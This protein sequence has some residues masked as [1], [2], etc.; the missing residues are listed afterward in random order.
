MFATFC[1]SV[2]GVFE[3]MVWFGFWFGLFLVVLVLGMFSLGGDFLSYF[4]CL[5]F[6]T[7]EQS[8]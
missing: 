6:K 5:P 7:E 3:L 1:E 2:F 4:F 8:S